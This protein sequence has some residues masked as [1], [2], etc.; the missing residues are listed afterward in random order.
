MKKIYLLSLLLIISQQLIAQR[1]FQAQNSYA[2]PAHLNVK[3][4]VLQDR[5]T[6]LPASLAQQCGGDLVL[7]TDSAGGYL[8]G[9]N[10]Y[11]DLEKMQKY[12]VDG[13][14]T[15]MSA[16]VIFGGKTQANPQS[17]L[18]AKVYSVGANGGPAT[19]LG[20]SQPV[21]ISSVDTAGISFTTF[22]FASPV[23]V[24][25]SFFVGFVNPT[26]PGDTVGA[27]TTRD[28]CFSGAG[29]AWE[30]WSDQTFAALDDTAGWDLQADLMIFPVVSELVTSSNT[31][32]AQRVLKL[33][34]AFPNPA[35]A[36]T[37]IMYELKERA[38]VSIELYDLTGKKVI[39]IDKGT[40]QAGTYKNEIDTSSLEGG[41]YFYT[42][43]TDRA[44]LTGRLHV[45]K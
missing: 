22:T 20:A 6:L 4:G 24:S 18:Y 8:A 26:T 23:T 5:D 16:L 27:V 11:G 45:A 43:R 29:F 39:D 34:N 21:P 36:Y 2:A 33:E 32:E 15:V 19:E 31:A 3:R 25:D 42:V 40:L 44:A 41:V 17:V 9:N 14:T 13:Q 1:L 30:K 28:E 37:T 12:R 10:S 35:E 7:Y 38:T